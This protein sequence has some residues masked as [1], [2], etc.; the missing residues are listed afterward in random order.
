MYAGI[1]RY[2]SS[3][4]PMVRPPY[5]PRPGAVAVMP[6][7][8]RPPIGGLRA[9]VIPL[10]V[11]AVTPVVIPA[12]KPQTT[13]FVGKIASAV[14]NDFM[15]SLLQLCGPVKSWKRA[16]VSPSGALKGFG[17][18]E[19]ES[20]E[21]VL[22][23]L[24]LLNKLSIDGQELTINVNQSTREYLVR[25]V[26]KKVES[27]KT[28]NET[29]TENAKRDEVDATGDKMNETPKA[30]SELSKP[31]ETEK[32]GNDATANKENVDAAIFGLITDEDRQSDQEALEKINAMIDERMKNKP[33]PP[34][35]SLAVHDGS[36]N[37]KPEVPS[38]SKD[39]ELDLDATKDVAE[40]KN[41][42]EMISESKSSGEQ[43]RPETTSPDKRVDRRSKDR[44]RDL[45]RER[46]LERYERE[47]EQ[48]RA[49]REKERE[50]RIREDER[51]YKSREKE[52]EARER[53]KEHWR[54]R[55]K[56]REKERAQER[57]WEITNQESDDGYSKKRKYKSN[58]E[59]RRR[60]QR[61]KEED[62]AD[63]LKEEEE[64]AEDKR[65]AEELLK[66]K[67]QE[68]ELKLSEKPANESNPAIPDE[69]NIESK[70]KPIQQNS[71]SDVGVDNHMG[72][73]IIQNGV[74]DESVGASLSVPDSR[75]N[76]NAPA[77]KLGFGLLG[78]GKRTAVPSVFNQDEDEDMQKEKKM[79]PLVPIDYSTE[80]QLA[81]Q[82]TVNEA[83][84]SNIVA[85]AEFAKRISSATVKE[86]K[87]DIEKDRS[88]RSHDRYGQRDRDRNIDEPTRSR[89]DTKKENFDRDRMREHGV[90][91][92][93]APDN[94]KLMDAKQLIDM[95]P[96]TKD[97]LFSFEIN[98]ETYDKNALHERM[99]PW[100][101]KKITE[102]LGE[103]EPT[104]VDYIV[105]STQE[106][107]K[108]TEMLD[109]L[110]GILDEEA[111]MFVL[112][113]WRML[114]FEIKRVETG[115]AMRS[116]A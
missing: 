66:K 61:E 102:F 99:R 16:Q 58:D 44:D 114:I 106:H 60:R 1:L 18:C 46:E 41:G 23:A 82:S 98:W 95:I 53:E 38:R 27:S 63:R 97:E 50:Y 67:Q 13:V 107:V 70:G 84:S 64:Q 69:T 11:R 85:A 78:S 7:L 24:R 42:N 29:V 112:K 75:H 25:F 37:S 14:E 57:K 31:E 110:Q 48:E 32:G 109:R 51:R 5:P 26:D 111:E 80:E 6:P 19:F 35:P 105:S 21:G 81:V 88:R 4:A 45:K 113:M 12:E 40:D 73:G 56:E 52:W 10:G 54:K 115:L 3:Y 20:A 47:R 76:S 71:D 8:S 96:K 59:E 36:A 34:P 17:F 62:L 94:Q 89:D 74:S 79:R 43:D 90:E 93:K 91:K 9:P 30:S 86:E 100:I 108:G 22:R 15:L 2:P 49:K 39:G 72:E 33:L 83:P 55:E 77:K 87:P 101:S 116:K 65:R 28:V 104:L 68:E 103:E 92:V